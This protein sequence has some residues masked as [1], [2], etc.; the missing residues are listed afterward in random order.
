MTPP[1]P[2]VPRSNPTSPTLN[3]PATFVTRQSST[4][5]SPAP[6]RT[7]NTAALFSSSVED[8][9]GTAPESENPRGSLHAASAPPQANFPRELDGPQQED[10]EN[11]P[12][13]I[14]AA[15]RNTSAIRTNASSTWGNDTY[16]ASENYNQS[17]SGGFGD[18]PGIEPRHGS[19]GGLGGVNRLNGN[20]NGGDGINDY[21][22]NG[23]VVGSGLERI[24]AAMKAPEEIVT[25]N[26]LPEKEGMFMF[27][28]RNYQIASARRGSRVVRRYSDFVW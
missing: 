20:G 17:I 15:L 21:R 1:P 13:D 19:F 22:V 16:T 12:D 10:E 8:P 11:E 18:H 6:V 23:N 7:R 28:H 24:K 4:P 5:I 9:W 14:H 2:Q 25:I 26:V 3:K 27:Q